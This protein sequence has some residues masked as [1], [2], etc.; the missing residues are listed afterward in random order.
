MRG[1]SECVVL[2]PLTWIGTYLDDEM[3]GWVDRES[4]LMLLLICVVSGGSPLRVL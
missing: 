1:T 4:C 3:N 2:G